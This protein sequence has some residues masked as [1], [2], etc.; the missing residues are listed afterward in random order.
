MNW[1]PLPSRCTWAAMTAPVDLLDPLAAAE[2]LG[3]PAFVWEKPSTRDSLVGFGVLASV[4]A[5]QP[6]MIAGL[7]DC[8]AAPGQFH[9]LQTS[10]PRPP[11]PWFGG[12]AFDPQRTAKESWEGFPPSR[13]ILPE[14]L[15]W[16]RGRQAYLTAFHPAAGP[17]GHARVSLEKR[18][19]QARERFR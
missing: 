14:L 8:L 18:L 19:A 3:T 7:V 15:V 13:W 5:P 2:R 17:D 16:I 12:I 11:G 9:W 10:L 4:E 1:R 6:G